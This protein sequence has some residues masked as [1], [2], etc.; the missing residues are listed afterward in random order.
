M[1]ITFG[2][3]A[4]TNIETGLYSCQSGRGLSL[5]TKMLTITLKEKDVLIDSTIVKNMF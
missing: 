5:Y 3:H 4:P 2:S 1:T